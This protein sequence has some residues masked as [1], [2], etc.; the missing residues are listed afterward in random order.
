[1]ILKGTVPAPYTAP[2]LT[3]WCRITCFLGE[4][5]IVIIQ[6]KGVCLKNVP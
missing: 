5:I 1:M 3:R 6:I 2:A 4:P